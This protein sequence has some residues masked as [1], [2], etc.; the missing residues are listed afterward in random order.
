MSKASFSFNATT[1]YEDS[2]EVNFIATNIPLL[3][4]FSAEKME[5]N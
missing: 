3:A 4:N 2:F 5:A 1:F